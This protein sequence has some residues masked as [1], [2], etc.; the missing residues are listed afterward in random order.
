[1]MVDGRQGKVYRIAERNSD[2]QCKVVAEPP[3]ETISVPTEYPS[4]RTQLMVN[5]SQP[6]SLAR[7]S[8]LPVDGIGL[9]RSELLALSVLDS[10]HPH[11]WLQ[12]GQG[13]ELAMRL[14]E[15]IKQFAQ[16]MLPRPVFFRGLDLRTHE[17]SGL[18]GSEAEATEVN[19]MLGIRGTFRYLINPALLDVQ[20]AAIAQV[21]QAGY[22]NVRLLLPFVRTV[23]EF[24]FCR[25][26]VQQA[27]LLSNPQF[28]IWIM[29]EVPSVLFL[30]S[31]YVRAGVQ[32]ISIGTNDLT[33]LLLGIDRDQGQMATMLDERHPAV[34]A[35]IA[36]LISQAK[37]LSIPCCLCGQAPV[38]Y[39]ELIEK[40]VQWGI[41]AIS[42]EPEAVQATYQA[43]ARAEQ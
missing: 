13:A 33:Q 43:I 30:L 16:A 14:A 23:E 17:F 36:Q 22:P 25:Q 20:L 4:L 8:A 7:V 37:Q 41:T 12:T 11:H 21:Q 15:Q 32:G 28:Q 24:R 35:A 3:L 5:L 10:R 31:E 2:L 6:D 18:V 39:P 19:P 34:M 9:L 42:V 40:L 1:V 26:R 29:A 38:H 27:G